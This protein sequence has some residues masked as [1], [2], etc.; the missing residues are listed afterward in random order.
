MRARDADARDLLEEAAK[1]RVSKKRLNL[2][3][4]GISMAALTSRLDRYFGPGSLLKFRTT[5]A[6]S[7]PA[8]GFCE[9]LAEDGVTPAMAQEVIDAAPSWVR[10]NLQLLYA[11]YFDDFELDYKVATE[12]PRPEE[13]DPK[14]IFDMGTAIGVNVDRACGT[15]LMFRLPE[16]FAA[17]DQAALERFEELVRACASVTT[18]PPVPGAGPLACV[19]PGV[20]SA[21]Y[22][23][24]LDPAPPP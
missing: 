19:T 5:Y 7:H 13:L 17:D 22:D 24:A 21:D 14:L 9:L 4:I 11:E 12:H 10:G 18:A 23:E 15:E 3:G 6:R 2:D 20:S 1:E 16:H 8:R